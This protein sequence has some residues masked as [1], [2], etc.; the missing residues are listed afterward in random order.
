[1]AENI[2]SEEKLG[3]VVDDL[4]SPY[5][6]IVPVAPVICAQ[7]EVVT[8]STLQRPLMNRVLRQLQELIA[9]NDKKN[10]FAI[11]LG[12]FIL[13]HSCSMTTRRD[14][15]Y[16]RQMLMT[17]SLHSMDPYTILIVYPY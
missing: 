13:L 16:A 4:S 14:Q 17:V 9:A 12:L 10:W 11:Y 1:M 8:F 5:F 2:C 7:L 3:T 15:E 6:G